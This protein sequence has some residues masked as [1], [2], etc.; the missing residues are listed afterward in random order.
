MK[1]LQWMVM[2]RHAKGDMGSGDL[3]RGKSMWNW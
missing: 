2:V 1:G 3:G